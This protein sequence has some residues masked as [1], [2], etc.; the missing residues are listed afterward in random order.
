[1]LMLEKNLICVKT[2][3]RLTEHG[4]RITSLT[5]ENMPHPATARRKI[6]VP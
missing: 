4:V 6:G 1:M 2:L 5:I 3:F